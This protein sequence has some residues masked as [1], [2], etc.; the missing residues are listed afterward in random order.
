LTP[1]RDAWMRWC[2]SR[3]QATPASSTTSQ[4][5]PS[6]TPPTQH[7]LPKKAHYSQL[8]STHPIS[9]TPWT[10]LLTPTISLQVHN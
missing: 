8:Y 3:R 7:H 4:W 2:C 6:L 1:G 9:F 10:V 5:H